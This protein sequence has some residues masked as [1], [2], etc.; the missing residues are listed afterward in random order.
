[1]ADTIL[2]SDGGENLQDEVYFSDPAS[3]TSVLL[4]NNYKQTELSW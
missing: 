3:K 1:M 2:T 4:E